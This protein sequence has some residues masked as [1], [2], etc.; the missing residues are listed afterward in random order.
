MPGPTLTR[1]K[2]WTDY[3]CG[4][5]SK[6]FFEQRHKIVEGF[7][8][9]ANETYIAD[10]SMIN[11]RF[12]LIGDWSVPYPHPEADVEDTA[13]LSR[14]VLPPPN[15]EKNLKRCQTVEMAPTHESPKN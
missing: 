12:Y 1:K 14:L 8:T 6:S 13:Y 2:L 4:H 7:C 9:A 5:V 11:E 15:G 3:W 10:E